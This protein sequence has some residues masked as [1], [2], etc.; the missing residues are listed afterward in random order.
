MVKA[1]TIRGLH[2]GVMAQ[3]ELTLRTGASRCGRHLAELRGHGV[4]ACGWAGWNDVLVGVAS[5]AVRHCIERKGIT[6]K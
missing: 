6:D 5:W 3:E 2:T 4:C 1:P